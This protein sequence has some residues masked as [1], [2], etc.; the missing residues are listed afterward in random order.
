M[1][2]R[3][4]SAKTA[5]YGFPQGF[6]RFPSTAAVREDITDDISPLVENIG[7]GAEDS[8]LLGGNNLELY[9]GSEDMENI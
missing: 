5:E 4:P 2:I 3:H 8:V 9:E 6:C 7:L 1:T